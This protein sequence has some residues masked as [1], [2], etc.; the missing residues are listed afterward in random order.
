MKLMSPVFLTNQHC[1]QGDW[2]CPSS[3]DYSDLNTINLLILQY[4]IQ[5]PP[6]EWSVPDP[7][8]P[9]PFKNIDAFQ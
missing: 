7:V 1:E 5:K 4:Y 2:R 3:Y 9:V 8:S 6:R